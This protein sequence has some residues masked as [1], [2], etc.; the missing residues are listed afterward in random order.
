MLQC[1]HTITKY[2]QVVN[3]IAAQ[4]FLAQAVMDDETGQALEYRQL[5]QGKNKEIW[6]K[7]CANEFGQLAQGVG[8]RIKEGTNTI[9]FINKNQM[10]K[11]RKATYARFI[12]DEQ[13]QK[14]EKH[15]TRITVG[16][17]LVDYPSN[18]HM[19]TAD[20]DLVKILFTSV[21]SDKTSKFCTIN[22]KNSYLNTPMTQYE[23]M[24]ILYAL[25]LDE[26]KE[27]YKLDEKVN[28]GYVYMEIRK[29]M[30]GLPQ[31]GHIAYDQLKEHLQK[32]GYR[33]E[34][35]TPGLWHH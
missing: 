31:A 28:D 16:G 35:Y 10:P 14:A 4:E 15:R 19:P 22:I 11:D 18:I 24:K 32:H 2:G 6:Y 3:H 30:Y 29:S 26:I 25:V 23:Y 34:K 27:Q 9:F 12:I 21:I 33:P 8:E 1:N 20:L 17:N 7:L 13:P 5:I